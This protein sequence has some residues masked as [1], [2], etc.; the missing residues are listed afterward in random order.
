MKA[1]QCYHEGHLGVIT[2]AQNSENQ[3]AYL[4]SIFILQTSLSSN[5]SK[6]DV[7]KIELVLTADDNNDETIILR[8]GG[9]S[10]SWLKA[11]EEPSCG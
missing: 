1:E 5:I 4:I 3:A 2:K 9:L 6:Y 7:N 11:Q 10:N 8:R